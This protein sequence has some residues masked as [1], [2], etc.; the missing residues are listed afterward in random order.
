MH[1]IGI[2]ELRCIRRHIGNSPV[3]RV[4][5]RVVDLQ[6][7]V[8]FT[9]W[10]FMSASL[11]LYIARYGSNSPYYDGW[12]MVPLLDGTRHVNAEWLWEPRNDHRI[13]IPKLVL[14]GLYKLT[15]WDFRVGMFA[16][17]ILLSASALVLILISAQLRG[18]VTYSDTFF[19]LVL[20]SWGHFEN[21]LWDWEITQ[22]IPVAVVL[23]LLSQIVRSGIR[24][25][26]R[27]AILSS[28]GIVLLPFCGVP[29]LAYVPGFALW[30]SAA[31]RYSWLKERRADRLIALFVWGLVTA[32][33]LMIPLYFLGLKTSVGE[34]K[35]IMTI[36]STIVAFLAHGFGPSVK[37]FLTL[38][39]LLTIALFSLAL[40]LVCWATQDKDLENRSRAWAMASFAF[41]F[42]G[43]CLSV[44]FARPGWTFPP[45]YFLQAV[46]ALCWAY[47]SF[48]LFGQKRS[49]KRVLALLTL[50]AISAMLFNSSIGLNYARARAKDFREMKTDL[51]AGMPVQELVARHQRAV[52]PYPESGGANWHEGLVA[53]MKSLRRAGI[54]VFTHLKEEPGFIE[55]PL[56]MLATLNSNDETGRWIW[57][58][59]K[60]TF[61]AGLRIVPIQ[62]R[63]NSHDPTLTQKTDI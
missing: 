53:S 45:R 7:A 6:S 16:N 57:N 50:V 56:D 15:R 60:E 47:F 30:L 42:A 20:T 2:V 61:I 52:W 63:N 29:G 39:Y 40:I 8:V 46:P 51:L 48:A 44:G 22:V 13:P 38:F 41:G 5:C 19:P 24:L 58:F 10:A 3:C 18:R 36:A 1:L 25:K 26:R 11:L 43:L 37:V 49:S 23:F 33:V 31:G 35:S 4:V 12:T 34:R 14:Y 32:A 54:G 55:T 28:L 17:A 59:H 21:L 9:V 27:D 62:I